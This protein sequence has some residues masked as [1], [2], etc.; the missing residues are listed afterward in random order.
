[1]S[2]EI[3]VEYLE[4][5]A[6]LLEFAILGY[7]DVIDQDEKTVAVTIPYGIDVTD[8]PPSKLVVSANDNVTPTIVERQ[9][10]TKPVIYTVTAEDPT[11][12]K[13]YDIIVEFAPEQTPDVEE[14][15]EEDDSTEEE[16]EETPSEDPVEE[17]D[18][19]EED[20][21]PED[22]EEIPEEDDE[23]I[24]EDDGP[25]PTGIALSF[26]PF[27][28]SAVTMVVSGKMGKKNTKDD[29]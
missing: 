23:E 6:D 27:I 28:V 13:K 8:T 10:F 21:V 2:Y 26:V 12:S 3:V 11:I 18:T 17:N 20:K 22:D 16:E 25:V 7:E 9:D 24:E 29:K 5:K 14:I 19:A 4:N 15:P 1:M